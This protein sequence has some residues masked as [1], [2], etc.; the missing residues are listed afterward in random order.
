MLYLPKYS[1]RGGVHPLSQKHE[2]K[3]PTRNVP[4][5]DFVSDAVVIPMN[6]HLG[7]PSKPCV[8]KGAHVRIG[9]VIGEP[10]GGLGLPVHASI[11]GEVTAVEPRIALGAAP[12]MCVCIQN[13]FA[14]E[15]VE[16]RGYGNVE[17]VD[18]SLVIP[19]VKNAGICGMGGAGFP[20][21]VKL[22]LPE[23]KTCDTVIVNGAE[24]ETFLTADFRLMVE[25]PEKIVDGLRAVMRALNVKRGVIAIEDNKPEAIEAVRAAASGRE[26]VEVAILR[27]KYPQGGEKQLIEAVTGR[28][29]PSGKLPIEAHTIVVNVGT[30]CAI[31][32]AV[33]D[34]RPLIDRITTVTGH[35]QNP[36][37]LRV[38]VGTVVGDVIG[39]CGGYS[40]EPGK[41]AMGG[42][43][44]GLCLP[45]DSLPIAKN[46]NGVV[47]YDEKEARS[48]EEEPCIRCA[49]CVDA[50]PIGLRPYLMKH[51]CDA[52][53]FEG[54]KDH[55][56]LECIL[57]GACSYSCPAK[58]WLTAS[59][60]LAKDSIAA[61]QRRKKS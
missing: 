45:D 52:G 46:N 57:C 51:Y 25:R 53:D 17:T 13:D 20:T 36:Q 50:C 22:T 9:Q 24:C 1:F 47:V 27:T 33:I 21:H 41:I 11:S 37:N 23:G 2:G 15:W 42:G 49:R 18:P 5:R 26:G 35:V 3:L 10:V 44:T 8:E 38:R 28:Q 6:M 59:F 39:E 61:A 48:V 14:E 12:A 29:V 40:C 30:A 4:I 16:T 56:V 58:R 43:M 54:A 7:A 34:G 60:K 55:D 32:D 31:A 19:A